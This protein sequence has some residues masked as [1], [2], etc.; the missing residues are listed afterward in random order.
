MTYIIIIIV[1]KSMYHE[2]RGR[3]LQDINIEWQHFL[4]KL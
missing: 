1:V 2:I 3:A 4:T